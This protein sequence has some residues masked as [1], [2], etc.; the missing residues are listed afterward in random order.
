[1]NTTLAPLPPSSSPARPRPRSTS[2]ASPAHTVGIVRLVEAKGLRS[3]WGQP[4]GRTRRI[5]LNAVGPHGAFGSIVIPSSS[6]V[7]AAR[8]CAPRSS[9]ATTP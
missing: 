4:H 3:T 6:S 8:C 2:P 5:I 7:P 1:M 9:T